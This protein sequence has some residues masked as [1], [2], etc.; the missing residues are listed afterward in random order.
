[1][2][3]N[4]FSTFSGVKQYTSMDCD[5][6]DS[7][8]TSVELAASKSEE[9]GGVIWLS[10]SRKTEEKKICHWRKIQHLHIRFLG[11]QRFLFVTLTVK[12][13]FFLLLEERTY[14]ESMRVTNLSA[15]CN[16]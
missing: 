5:L 16:I 15:Y 10:A 2:N 9:D 3:Q 1:M 7:L 14:R 11:N 6:I 4:I 13:S 8:T 12:G